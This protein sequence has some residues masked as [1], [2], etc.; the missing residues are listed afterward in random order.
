MS[1]KEVTND[2]KPIRIGV[3]ASLTG[4]GAN[5]GI[6]MVNGLNTWLDQTHHEI[7]KRKVELIIED[8]AGNPATGIT[9]FE[10]LV[11]KDKVD[12]VDGIV[13]S[14]IA[15]AIAP[16][17]DDYKTPVV[18]AESGA[19]DLTKNKRHTWLLRSGYSSSQLSM[20]FGD[21]AFKTLHYKK[22]ATIGQNFPFSW[23]MVGGFP[24]RI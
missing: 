18:I 20:P 7:G 13:L 2:S 10:K 6:D 8:D 22:I 4:V 9:K 17:V 1:Q 15:Y 23:E 5:A 19:D 16:H 12:I 21:Y 14:N 11:Q 3:L 24:Q